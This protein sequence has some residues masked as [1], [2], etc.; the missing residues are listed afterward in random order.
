MQFAELLL[1]SRTFF[2]LRSIQ[3][4]QLC[5]KKYFVSH[6]LSLS[7]RNNRVL[8]GTF[9][10]F[11]FLNKVHFDYFESQENCSLFHVPLTSLYFFVNFSC[12]FSFEKKKRKFYGVESD[13]VMDLRKENAKK[14]KKSRRRRNWRNE[15]AEEKQEYSFSYK[16]MFQ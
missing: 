7:F 1:N 8:C 2:C 9:S 11:H 12:T 13:F 16:L 5:A 10:I 4:L 14:G 6:S 3:W 15:L